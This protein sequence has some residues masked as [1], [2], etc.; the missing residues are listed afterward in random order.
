MT[1]PERLRI[2]PFKE[3]SF[4][5]SLHSPRLA[6]VLGM[7][8]GVAFTLCFV[9]GLLSHLIQHPPTW[10][11]WPSRPAG[12]YRITQGVHVATGLASIPLLLAKLWTVYPHLWRWPPVR[13]V[14]HLIERV[15]LLPLVA[16]SIFLLFTGLA[17]IG[18]WYPW[19]F[20]FPAG[21]YW[22]S[23]IT[24]G[25]LGVHIGAKASIVRRE[26]TSRS[27]D[28]VARPGERLT[29]RG[30]LGVVAATSGI[31]TLTTVGQT[32]SP[33]NVFGVLAPRRPDVGPQGF[34]VNKS[35]AAAGVTKAARHPGYRLEI[36]GRVQR[37]LH[38]SLEDLRALP[39]FEATLPISCVEGWSANAQWRGV[40]VRDLLEMARAGNDPTVLVES[41]Q[42]SGRYK[43]SELNP[44]HSSDEETLLALEVNGEVLHI[45]HGYPLR[46]IGP[47]RPGV[48]QT[49][50]VKKLIV[51]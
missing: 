12:L 40:R 25:A 6:T 39:Q 24:M 21:H 26:L 22:G 42:P 16:G 7:A 32:F 48:M 1:P 11:E 35:A 2:G 10:F 36:A 31:I 3:G 20:F 23:W 29:R 19:R 46:L 13:D 49:K 9:T 18:L 51:L 47:N 50:W 27:L 44:S 17:N 14:T 15:A 41:M 45:D 8:L 30:F 38:L 28:V 33:L 4:P 43:S 34:P 5:S 37:R